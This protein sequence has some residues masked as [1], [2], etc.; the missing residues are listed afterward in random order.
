MFWLSNRVVK[1][2]VEVYSTFTVYPR[3]PGN[4]FTLA[5]ALHIPCLALPFI[6]WRV[7]MDRKS[8]DSAIA[9]PSVGTYSITV[10]LLHALLHHPGASSTINVSQYIISSTLPPPFSILSTPL[11]C[12]T[13]IQ[14][15]LPNHHIQNTAATMPFYNSKSYFTNSSSNNRQGNSNS[16]SSSN[17]RGQQIQGGETDTSPRC[18]KCREPLVGANLGA[19]GVALTCEGCGPR[20]RL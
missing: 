11:I 8:F 20:G 10:R 5:V 9:L 18:S 4:H 6:F 17:T 14:T 13:P 3:L 1:S 7:T 15:L 2:G 12:Q 19:G 16:N